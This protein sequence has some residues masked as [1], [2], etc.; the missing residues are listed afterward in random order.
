MDAYRTHVAA[1][2]RRAL[3]IYVPFVANAQFDEA[4]AEEDDDGALDELAPR[5]RLDGT[6]VMPNAEEE[7]APRRHQYL[8]AVETALRATSLEEVRPALSVPQE[9]RALAEH[10]DALPGPGLPVYR[11]RHQVAFWS[12]L[13]VYLLVAGWTRGV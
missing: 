6:M 3:G 8:S 12:G 9:F 11:G 5:L 4:D 7:R 13:E 1:Q 2:N 10:V